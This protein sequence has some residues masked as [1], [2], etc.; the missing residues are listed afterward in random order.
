MKKIFTLIILMLAVVS[1]Q[2]KTDKLNATFG[3]TSNGSYDSSTSTFTWTATSNNYVNIF[4]GSAGF[5]SSYKTLHIG[6]SS[7]SSTFRV[8]IYCNGATSTASYTGTGF[9]ETQDIDLASVLKSASKSVSD[10]TLI[11]IFGSNATSDA[12]KKLVFDATGV[13]LESEPY[14][15]MKLTTSLGSN[16]TFASPFTW[17]KYTSGVIS[18]YGTSKIGNNSIGSDRTTT[19]AIYGYNN[20]NAVTTAFFDITDYDQ[21]HITYETGKLGTVRFLCTSEYAVAATA[22]AFTPTETDE[23]YDISSLKYCVSIK[24]NSSGTINLHINSLDLIKNFNDNSTTDFSFVYDVA[25]TSVNYDRSFT[26]GQK[27]TICLPF[28]LTKAEMDAMGTFYY[29][30]SVTSESLDFQPASNSVNAYTPYIFVPSGTGTVT[31]FSNLANKTIEA[32]EGK[33]ATVTK[34]TNYT[35]KGTLSASSNVQGDN[36]G[37]TVYGFS[38]DTFVKVNDSDISIKAF[39]AYIVV[40]T[41]SA[42]APA[43]LSISF[44]NDNVTGIQTVRTA[45]NVENDAAYNLAGQR[46]GENHKGLVIKNGKKYFV[47]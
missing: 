22:T 45:D 7:V 27:Y 47:K 15:T 37:S 43:R 46:V 23:T 29:F 13:Y 6:V 38:N 21:A 5:A 3:S 2:A 36:T 14:E 4:N 17:K 34:N 24:P 31:P 35:F 33:T 30:N 41:S 9:T 11:R 19:N 28:S 8:M 39:R 16:D 10:I 26:A 18:D 25:N 44:G 20:S 12:T 42:A 40:S 1:V 32:S